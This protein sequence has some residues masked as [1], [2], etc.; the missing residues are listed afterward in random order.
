LHRAIN[1]GASEPIMMVYGLATLEYKRAFSGRKDLWM[2]QSLRPRNID[3]LRAVSDQLR[4]VSER[5][6]YGFFGIAPG[7]NR[8]DKSLALAASARNGPTWKIS[9]MVRRSEECV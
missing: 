8:S 7:S 2:L 3:Q 1:T 9:C 4:A 5:V 6:F